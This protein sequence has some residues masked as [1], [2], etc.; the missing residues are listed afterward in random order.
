MTIR[1]FSF[2]NK[3]AKKAFSVRFLQFRRVDVTEFFSCSCSFGVLIT[4]CAPLLFSG[5]VLSTDKRFIRSVDI[6][7]ESIIDY[8]VY[9][10]GRRLPRVR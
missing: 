10:S 3:T 7:S 4:V 5:V 8:N 2:I 9:Y 6:T 1:I